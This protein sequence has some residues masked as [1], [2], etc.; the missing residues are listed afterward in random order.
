MDSR[1]I[2]PMV[3]VIDSEESSAKAEPVKR[4]RG[5]P[6]GSKGKPTLKLQ[7]LTVPEFSFFRASLQGVAFQ[8]AAPRFIP[9]R[10]L[11]NSE[12]VASYLKFQFETIISAGKKQLQVV[13]QNSQEFHALN[14]A[15]DDLSFFWFGRQN[16]TKSEEPS[17]SRKQFVW[18]LDDFMTEEGIAEDFYGESELLEL[19]EVAYN[20]KKVLFEKKKV[21]SETPQATLTASKVSV[22]SA[23][24]ALGLLQSLLVVSPRPD[25]A[26]DGWISANMAQKFKAHGVRTLAQLGKW[27]NRNG[28]SW[29][30][31]VA[32]VGRKKA[33]SITQWLYTNEE[34][35]GVRIDRHVVDSALHYLG[36]KTTLSES[37]TSPVCQD[38][39]PLQDVQW[40]SA[41]NGA[42]GLYRSSDENTY[43]AMNDKQAV[44]AWLASLKTANK[45]TQL[46]Y[47]RAVER[48]VLWSLFVKGVAISS[49]ASADL[50]EF[51][52]FLRDPPTSWI[53]KAPAV[54]GSVLWKPMRGGLSDKSLELNVQAVKQ[55]FSSWFNAN[56]LKANAAKGA[57]YLKRKAASMD[58]MR[59][60]TVQ[61]LAYIKRTLDAMPPGPSQNRQKALMMLLLTTGMRARE[62]INQKWKYV[63]QARIGMTS[64]SDYVISLIGK[65]EKERILPIRSD[66]Y[67]ALKIHL[68]DRKALSKTDKLSSF[69]HFSDVD[70]PLIGIIDETK[71]QQSDGADSD[72][73]YDCAR[74]GNFDGSISYERF[75]NI[76]TTFFK[77]CADLCDSEGQDSL[78]L[79]QATPHWMRHTFA[80]AVLDATDKDLVV[81]QSLLGH[82]DLSTTG[83]Y[84]K[85]DVEK[86]VQS[87]KKIPAFL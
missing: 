45:N 83:L 3:S 17:H 54:K 84:V 21:N 51:F 39:C 38:L 62:L 72:Y 73:A 27:V 34:Y 77:Q 82:S 29:H 58:V 74:K 28:N 60:F 8:K 79:R 15:I 66:V 75:K 2:H 31:E 19:Y 64:T 36:Q 4:S 42:N 61:D 78:R 30:K 14:T 50:A 7:A 46:A 87:V 33:A 24:S 57:G 5:R 18:S 85:A 81:V 80:H 9:E 26:L 69:S 63:S 49:L 23:I 32:S 22:D 55:M 48:L 71:A 65:G 10:A 86:R 43:K 41:L 44:E 13:D 12:Q 1:V 25:D 20:E 59:S 6:L 37:I 16:S 70:W 67:N 52:D 11:M 76:V 40:P 47:A 35:T 68:E 53:Q 56:Y